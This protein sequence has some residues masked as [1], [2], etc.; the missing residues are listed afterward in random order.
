MAYIPYNKPYKKPSDLVS[1]LK[2]KNLS[3]HD[4]NKAE[5]L[6]SNISYYHFKIYLHPLIDKNSQNIKNYKDGSYFETGVELYRFDEELRALM[7]KVIARLEVKFR[8]H[9]DHKMSIISNNSF[10]YLDNNWFFNSNNDPRKIN[11][12]RDKISIDFNR[13]SELYARNFRSKY[14]NE[15]HDNYKS[16]PPFFIASEIISLG[17]LY[18]IYDSIDF[19]KVTKLPSPSNKA[20]HDLSNDFGA[21]KF[22]TLVNWIMCIRNMRNRCAHHSRLWNAKLAAVHDI[23]S[24]LDKLPIHNNRPYGTIAVIAHMINKLE[25]DFNLFNELKELFDKYS[26]AKIHINDAGFPSDWDADPF[27]EKFQ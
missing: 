11:Q 22:K 12:V 6:L 3:F 26:S 25:I 7:F 24:I 15:I 4:E 23:N 19:S 18:K 2:S 8:S 5:K 20:L 16:L 13:E 10:W 14:Y 1:D 9:L 17:Q 21:S 27:W